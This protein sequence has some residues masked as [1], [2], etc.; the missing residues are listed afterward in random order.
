[1]KAATDPKIPSVIVVSILRL[2]SLVKFANTQNI[3]CKG[4]TT[5]GT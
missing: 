5:A 4:H 3:T 1:M 2:T